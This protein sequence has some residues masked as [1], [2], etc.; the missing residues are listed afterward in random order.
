MA[1]PSHFIAFK[2]GKTA[3]GDETDFAMISQ[4]AEMYGRN[5]FEQLAFGMLN[6]TPYTQGEVT[7][8]GKTSKEDID[9]A[10]EEVKNLN[11]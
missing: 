7:F 10:R 2:N 9:R 4:I 6:D 1:T 5:P 8:A 11:S 3:F